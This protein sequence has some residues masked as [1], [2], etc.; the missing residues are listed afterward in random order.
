M[1]QAGRK[2]HAIHKA[3]HAQRGFGQEKRKLAPEGTD[4]MWVPEFLSA[5]AGIGSFNADAIICLPLG[6]THMEREQK[7]R[8]AS[9]MGVLRMSAYREAGAFIEYRWTLA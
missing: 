3:Q 6:H 9:A 4:T 2:A 5:A 7:L 1:S 8:Q